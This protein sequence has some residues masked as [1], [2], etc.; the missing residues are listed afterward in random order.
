MVL[1]ACGGVMDPGI[2]SDAGVAVVPPGG[3]VSDTTTNLTV[4]LLVP[5]ATSVPVNADVLIRFSEPV[6]TTG[7]PDAGSGAF[8]TPLIQLSPANLN[9][10][11]YQYEWFDENQ[12]LRLTAN[13][14]DQKD[15]PQV[16]WTPGQTYTIAFSGELK[17][18]SGKTLG[19]AVSL[20]FTA[21]K[22][23][24]TTAPRVV[25]IFE[26][27]N[28]E[29]A[30][31][32]QPLVIQFSEPMQASTVLAA[33]TAGAV[34]QQACV[35]DAQGIS[36]ESISI[37]YQDATA[38]YQAGLSISE[39]GMTY[40]FTPPDQST[41]PGVSVESLGFALSVAALDTSGN[42]L[43]APAQLGSTSNPFTLAQ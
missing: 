7:A 42:A 6:V 8:P 5:D 36:C 40:T 10:L 33:L 27:P 26:Q 41:A 1:A 22:T 25:Q 39:D 3:V 17:G 9:G 20:T 14:L 23:P 12:T 11:G 29:P 28:S 16:A 13:Q 18:V 35:P 37:H 21:A 38:L 34:V 32:W 4:S 31:G 2:V 43:A 24:D 19:Q 30:V 15:T